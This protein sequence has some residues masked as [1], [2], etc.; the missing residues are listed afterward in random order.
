MNLLSEVRLDNRKEKIRTHKL[1]GVL[2]EQLKK[3]VR[4]RDENFDNYFLYILIDPDRCRYTVDVLFV[5]ILTVSIHASCSY[6]GT[7]DVS[8]TC[9]IRVS[10][11]CS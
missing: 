4:Y 6:T 10:K 7:M 3:L 11:P 8:F 5:G 2:Q 1:K 9:N